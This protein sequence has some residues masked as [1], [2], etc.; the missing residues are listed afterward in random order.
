MNP[1]ALLEHWKVIGI[2]LLLAAIAIQTFRL[3]DI[4]NEYEYFKLE[5][6]AAA[7]SAK[8]KADAQN[9]H[10]DMIREELEHDIQ[11]AKHERDRERAA[12]GKASDQFARLYSQYYG[13]LNSGPGGGGVP[14]AGD[15]AAEPVSGLR[16]CFDRAR[17]VESV[18]RELGTLYSE[19]EPLVRSG[20]DGVDAG[21]HWVRWARLAG[22]CQKP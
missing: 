9:A 12:R 13:L 4:E 6:Q 17:F 8:A 11:Q 15:G 3:Q 1:L 19:L 18:Q 20:E 7:R 21:I 2:G 22:A 10:N 14:Q 16:V 5:I